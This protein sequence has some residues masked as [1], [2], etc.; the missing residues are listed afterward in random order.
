M[1]GE[2][3]PPHE[4]HLSHARG[5]ILGLGAENPPVMAR[6]G[7][8]CTACHTTG[9]PAYGD[10]NGDICNVC[11]S[12]GGVY[13]GVNNSQLGALNNWENMGSADGATQSMIYNVDGTLK[14]EKKKWCATCHDESAGAV[15]DDFEGYVDSADLQTKWK[16]GVDTSDRTLMPHYYDK[17]Q[18]GDYI[19]YKDFD[20]V[21][22]H[23]NW[24]AV[25]NFDSIRGQYMRVDLNSAN[26]TAYYGNIRRDFTPPLDLSG[27]DS[28]NLYL[29]VVDKS[30]ITK[31]RVKLRN[32]EAWA[33]SQEFVTAKY[34]YQNNVWKMI[35]LPRESFTITTDAHW[36]SLD[37]ISILIYDNETESYTTTVYLDEIGCS[38]TVRNVVGDDQ[39]WGCYKT[40][41][42]FCTYCHDPGSEHIDGKKADIFDYVQNETNPT[43]FRFYNDPTKQ[44]ELPYNDELVPGETG[45]FALCYQ[46]H[47]ESN[48][49][50]AAPVGDLLGVT[51]FTDKGYIPLTGKDNL[52]LIHLNFTPVVFNMTCVACHDPH[53]QFN[54]AMTR[55]EM[56]DLFYFDPNGCKIS[57][58]ADW[59]DADVNVGAAQRTE[60]YGP[61]CA[62]VCHGD[63]VPPNEPP[64]NP[65]NDPYANYDPGM[66]GFYVRAYAYVRHGGATD[67]G[68]DCFS[69]G[70][71]AVNQMHAAHF[72]SGTGPGFPLNE[73]GCNECHADGH[74]QCGDGPLFRDDPPQYLSGTEACDS[75]HRPGGPYPD[76]P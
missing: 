23:M 74:T 16:Q 45:S 43:N 30:L 55:Y 21:V 36:G 32:A 31:I 25:Y 59:Y 8:D 75:C 12:P 20:D 46:C 65:G 18:Y 66:D 48:F 10:V 61:L 62:N 29:K 3:D 27:M 22:S 34:G 67:V 40:G 63:V 11:H 4:T 24:T 54:P 64:C 47:E 14:E 1:A 73:I 39:N 2:S 28:I 53:G 56:G 33:W 15:L 35:S 68:T 6:V 17:D 41:H 9:T 5:P 69:V 13:D 7:D 52:H 42:G 70:C 38:S 60:Y 72:V 50:T 58:Q 51:N 71:H 57:D 76:S 26:N 49:M 37:R 44:M 19:Y